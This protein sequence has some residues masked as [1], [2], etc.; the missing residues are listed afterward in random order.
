[1][2]RFVH[3]IAPR[4]SAIQLIALALVVIVSASPL[5]ACTEAGGEDGVNY[6]SGDISKGKLPSDDPKL[7]AQRCQQEPKMQQTPRYRCSLKS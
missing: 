6:S 1:M 5:T 4:R 2:S 7:C 3:L